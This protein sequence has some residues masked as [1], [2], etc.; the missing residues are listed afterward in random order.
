MTAELNF[1]VINV[2]HCGFSETCGIKDLRSPQHFKGSEVLGAMNRYSAGLLL[3]TIY[4][5][6]VNQ[7]LFQKKTNLYCFSGEIKSVQCTF[8]G[9]FTAFSGVLTFKRSM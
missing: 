4:V 6:N 5:Y 7:H 8:R 1:S 9:F 3:V 2:L